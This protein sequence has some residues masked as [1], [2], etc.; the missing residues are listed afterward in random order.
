MMNDP[1]VGTRITTNAAHERRRPKVLMAERKRAA[2]S[3]LKG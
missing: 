1:P 3:K 2:G